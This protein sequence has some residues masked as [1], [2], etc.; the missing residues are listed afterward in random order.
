[1]YRQLPAYAK[2]ELLATGPNQVWR[3]DITKLKGPIKGTWLCLYVILDIFSRAV[4]G[5]MVAYRQS[6]ALAE[7]L[8]RQ[9]VCKHAFARDRLP[10]SSP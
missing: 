8:I 9:T 1:M 10:N 2:P 6:A 4:V 7:R 5:W 3:R